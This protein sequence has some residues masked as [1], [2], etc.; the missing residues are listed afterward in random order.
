MRKLALVTII[1]ALTSGSAIAATQ[2]AP[3]QALTMLAQQEKLFEQ[4]VIQTAENVFTAVGFHGAT[5][6][7]I[8]GDDGVI[9]VD[10]LMG[11]TS[12]S[13]AFKAL[14]QYSD[15]PVKAIIYTHSHGDHTGGASVFAGDDQPEIISMAN[16]GHDHGV[17]PAINPIMK[18]RGIRQFGRKLPLEQATNRGLAPAH[19]IDHDRGKGHLPAT[20]KIEGDNYKTTIAGIELEMYGVIGET[21][22]ALYLWLPNEKVLFSGDN[23][24]QTFPNLYAIRGTGYRNVLNWADSVAQMATHKPEFV[25]PGHTMPIKGQQAATG[26][27]QDYSDAIRSVYDQT[28]VAINQGKGPDLI[29]HEVELPPHLKNKPYLTEFYGNIAHATRAIYAGLLGWFDGNPTNLSPLAPKQKAMKMAQLAG[30]VEAL[31]IKMNTALQAEDFQWALELA[32]HLKWLDNGDKVLAKKVKIAA[33]RGLG[34]REYNAPNR[35]YYLSYAN[36]LES[37]QLSKIWF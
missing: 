14:R 12:A 8:V 17:D 22:D 1:A 36:E 25:V 11:P 21:N 4:S 20:Y 3:Q 5:T 26:A 31:T 18:P 23:F 19:T 37:G 9:I 15:K 7:M 16:F 33:L 34:A 27:L 32:D 24:Y 10:T 6:S 2:V 30:G 29:A 13:N 35:N 28:I